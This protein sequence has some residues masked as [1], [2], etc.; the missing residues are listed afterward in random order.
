VAKIRVQGQFL[1]G[2]F[3]FSFFVEKA[4]FDCF[5]GCKSLFWLHWRCIEN[6]VF[7]GTLQL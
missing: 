7:S 5:T 3:Q 4:G 2:V 1:I 6:P